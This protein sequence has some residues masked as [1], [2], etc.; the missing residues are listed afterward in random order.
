MASHTLQ[1]IEWLEIP[2][3]EYLKNWAQLFHEIKFFNCTSET[4]FSEIT[5]FRGG[6]L[7]EMVIY[8]D[9]IESFGN[10]IR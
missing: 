7:K 10:M 8:C 5:F 1:L 4:M 3:I 9:I 2:N 6:N